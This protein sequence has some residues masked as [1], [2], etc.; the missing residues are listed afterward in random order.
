MDLAIVILD[1]EDLIALLYL[2]LLSALSMDHAMM[3]D[4]HAD[5]GGPEMTVL[6]EHAQMLVLVM[7]FVEIILVNVMLV[8]V[9]LTVVIYSAPIRVQVKELATT[10]LVIAK[11]LS[12]VQIVPFVL[13]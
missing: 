7:V 4:V 8:S 12:E 10:E 9:V 11:V 13:V 3:E 1:S 2:A 5:L 6:S